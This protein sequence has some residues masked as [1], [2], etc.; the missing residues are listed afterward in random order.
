MKEKYSPSLDQCRGY[1][2]AI[3]RGL[4][5]EMKEILNLL[6]EAIQNANHDEIIHIM[7]IELPNIES[8]LRQ[9]LMF[10]LHALSNMDYLTKIEQDYQEE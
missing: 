3:I 7:S 4:K 6:N 8:I 5:K 2:E 9:K 10:N 1:N